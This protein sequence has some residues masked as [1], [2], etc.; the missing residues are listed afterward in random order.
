MA[1]IVYYGGDSEELLSI[2]QALESSSHTLFYANCILSA[3]ELCTK[4]KPDLVILLEKP[5]PLDA[6]DFLKIRQTQVELAA[7]HCLVLSKGSLRRLAYYELACNA[8]IELPISPK[9]L[10]LRVEMLL[11]DTGNQSASS[12]SG[13]TGS[14]EHAS[15]V[16]LLQ[17]LVAA[18]K[19]GICKI[20]TPNRL[21]TFY[22]EGGQVVHAVTESEEGE[23]AF[24]TILRASQGEGS[25]E[26]HAQELEG[27][28]TTIEKR[29]DHLLL[30]LASI[31]DEESMD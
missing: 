16:D 6:L 31:L 8:H 14:F 11:S 5:G 7:L 15:L 19:Q 21:G 25:F 1:K 24:L 22:F 26:F 29:T 20:N 23:D 30:G 13:L 10:L 12:S 18:G 27:I 17:M 9:E 28:P 4:E 3:I 2:A